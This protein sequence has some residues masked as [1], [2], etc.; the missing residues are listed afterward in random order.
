MKTR[1]Y[2]IAVALVALM[3]LQAWP[4]GAQ[5]VREELVRESTVEQVLKRGV[6][7][8]GLSTFLPWAMRDKKG[9]L[10]GFEVDGPPSRR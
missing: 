4:A 2:V 6:L 8:V 3:I 1:H 7:R 10:I 5:K 9:N